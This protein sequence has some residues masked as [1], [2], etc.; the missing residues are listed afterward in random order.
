ML[1]NQLVS[2][3]GITDAVQEDHSVFGFI[4]SQS[5]RAAVLTCRP[6]VRVRAGNP[7]Y[8]GELKAKVDAEVQRI[9]GD[10]ALQAR[11]KEMVAAA[12]AAAEAEAVAEPAVEPQPVPQSE[13]E[14]APAQPPAAEEAVPPVLAGL[15]AMASAQMIKIAAALGLDEDEIDEA[16]DME[17]E[18][19]RAAHVRGL[20][21]ARWVY[22]TVS[23]QLRTPPSVRHTR[24]RAHTHTCCA[25]LT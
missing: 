12:R 14:P 17:T 18:A 21:E 7:G 4:A 22:T 25:D 10:P 23:T 20:I 19:E 9:Q 3:G 8:A 15:Q 11:V 16:E 5:C 24:A 6:R 13:P 2:T 1:R